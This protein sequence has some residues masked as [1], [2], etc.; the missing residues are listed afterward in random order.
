[1]AAALVRE[2]AP[3]GAACAHL[4]AVV[5]A[6]L[7][8]AAAARGRLHGAWRRGAPP[9][10]LAE[11]AQR[12]AAAAA[13]RAAAAGVSDAEAAAL[14]PAV[15]LAAVYPLALLAETE[16]AAAGAAHE[17]GETEDGDE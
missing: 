10:A 17:A 8:E 6:Q 2:R 4:G 3:V 16:V 1:M 13:A 5:E 15:A 9:A 12:A 11:A 7:A 14:A